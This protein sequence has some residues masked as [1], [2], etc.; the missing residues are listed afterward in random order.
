MPAA[1]I[2]ALHESGT[3]QDCLDQVIILW[4]ENTE[5]KSQVE[6]LQAE[7]RYLKNKAQK[8]IFE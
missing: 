4:N 8:P 2:N 7:L 5:L 1:F 3:K 6:R